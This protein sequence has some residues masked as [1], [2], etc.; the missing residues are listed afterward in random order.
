MA[1][2]QP[3]E[4]EGRAFELVTEREVRWPP[5]SV[6]DALALKLVIQD[7]QKA[8]SFIAIKGVLYDWNEADRLLMFKVPT[9]YWEGTLVPRASL[10]IPLVYEHIESIMPQIMSLFQEEPPFYSKPLPGTSMDAARANDALINWQLKEIGFRNQMKLLAQSSL[11]Y[12]MGIGKWGW[13]FGTKHNQMVRRSKPQEFLKTP[14]GGVNVDQKGSDKLEIVTREELVNEPTFEWIDNRHLLVD[15]GLREPDIRKAKFVIHREYL[16]AEGLDDLRDKP[17]YNIPSRAKLLE[18]FFA[19][20]EAAKANPLET[21]SINIAKDFKATPP[22]EFS[23]ID[24]LKQPLEVLERW[25]E[26]RVYTILQRKLVIRN[27]KNEFNTIPFVSAPYAGVLGSF[28]ALGIARLIGPEQKLQQGVMN[29]FLDDMS[30]GLNGMFV[31]TRGANAATQQMRMRPGGVI[32]VDEKDGISLLPRQPVAI[33]ALQVVSDSDSRAQRR[34]A[35]NELVVQGNLPSQ[36][37]SIT[38]T[39]TGVN[40]LSAGSGARLQSFIETISEFVMIPTL[41]AVHKM[42]SERLL[43]SQLE[44]ILTDELATAYKGDVIDLLNARVN[45]TMLAGAKLQA[46]RSLSQSLPLMFQFLLTEPVVQG[47][48]QQGKKVNIDELVKM[49]FETTGWPNQ[50]SVIESFSEEDEM[51]AASQNPLVQ[52]AAAARQQ[53]EAQRGN[54]LEFIEEENLARAGRDVIRT[55]LK[56]IEL[57]ATGKTG[58]LGGGGGDSR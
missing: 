1:I 52:Q 23:T 53:A 47:L 22:A 49:L 28:W 36:G 46:R 45:F 29:T 4:A 17:G 19:P 33:E 27:E 14:E 13:K 18:L 7:A 12:G 39:A 11:L 37:S 8:E 41:T 35:A 2:L 16:T 10:G 31:R 58:G 54:K 24:P 56:N 48:Q 43:P 32:D 42:N 57:E 26:D 44:S 34:T 25:D 6:P 55:L 50:Q 21:S 40:A 5:Q 38:R 30:L 15:P 9:Q 51:R 3:I 20:K